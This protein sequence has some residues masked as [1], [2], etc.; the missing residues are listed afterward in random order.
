MFR[1]GVHHLVLAGLLL[2]GL[3]GP[4]A[5]GAVTAEDLRVI[6]AALSHK[7]RTAPGSGKIRLDAQS[8]GV[9]AE[10]QLLRASCVAADAS[11]LEFLQRRMPELTADK[12]A[13]LAARNAQPQILTSPPAKDVVLISREEVAAMRPSLRRGDVHAFTSLPAYFGN[14]TALIFVGFWCGRGCGEGN[15][16]MLRRGAKGWKVH[17]AAMTWIS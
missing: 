17:K 6:D 5:P 12:L 13:A 16:L 9:C 3:Q 11:M 14:D 10:Q 8:L 15:F 2:A 4:P 7:A 1:W